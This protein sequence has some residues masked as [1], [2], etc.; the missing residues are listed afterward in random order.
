MGHLTEGALLAL[1]HGEFVEPLAVRHLEE[2]VR[3]AEHRDALRRDEQEL[4]ALFG[5]L[6]W[7]VT[8]P[9]PACIKG[10]ALAR[11]R[12]TGLVA[13]IATLMV[14]ASTAAALALSPV[15]QWVRDLLAPPGVAARPAASPRTVAFPPSEGVTWEPTGSAT[16]ELRYAQ[17]TGTLRL[18]STDLTT[19]SARAVGGDVGF[20]VGGGGVLLDNRRPAEHY[21]LVVPRNLSQ[22]SVW[23][24]GRLL[25]RMTAGDSTLSAGP[26]TFDLTHYPGRTP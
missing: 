26:L 11:G 7:P 17:H 20:R 6:D 16:F 13:A 5:S 19:A 4:D 14:L 24:G 12:R 9:T 23:V 21:E 18:V 8:P 15:R 22:V 1:L 10:R 2:C 3:C 25:I